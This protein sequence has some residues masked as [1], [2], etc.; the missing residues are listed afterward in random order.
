MSIIFDVQIK[1]LNP[2]ITRKPKLRR[3]RKIFRQQG[4][5]PR[6]EQMNI[7]VATWGRLLKKNIPLAANKSDLG[8]DQR[9][10]Q[11]SFAGKFHFTSNRC[12]I[13]VCQKKSL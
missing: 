9:Q 4:K 3:Q 13:P 2:L 8:G 12:I 5:M 10:D 1:F 7:N 11:E 6:P